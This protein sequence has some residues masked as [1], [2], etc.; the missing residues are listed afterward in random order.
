MACFN[1]SSLLLSAAL[2]ASTGLILATSSARAAECNV[3]ASPSSWG[4][5][6]SG[7]FQLA[8][9]ESCIYGIRIAGTFNSSRIAR[10][11]QHG[12]V[13]MIDISTFEYKSRDGYAGPD[14]FAIE[15]N[16][17][18]PTS[19]GTSVVTLNVVVKQ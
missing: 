10:P 9:G 18:S 7:T 11:A 19:S 12:N 2:L 17:T 16:G 3:A 15:A 13:R 8:A 1:K 6:M 4:S 5:S 14:S